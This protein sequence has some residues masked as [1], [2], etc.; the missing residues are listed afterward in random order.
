MKLPRGAG[1]DEFSQLALRH[2]VAVSPGSSFSPAEEHLDHIRVCFGLDP[3]T[4]R[5]AVPKLV[6][7]WRELESGAAAGRAGRVVAV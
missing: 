4:L 1:G 6:E 3:D 5:R 7:A 2:G